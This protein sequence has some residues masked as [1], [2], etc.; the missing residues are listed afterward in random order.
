MNNYKLYLDVGANDGRWGLEACVRDRGTQVF[1]FEPVPEMINIIK[2]N[3]QSVCNQVGFISYHLEP[4]AVSDFSGTAKFH[5]SPQA[6]WGCSSLLEFKPLEEIKKTWPNRPD[7]N[8]KFD[9]DVNVIKLEDWCAEH[10]IQVNGG[11]DFIHIDAQG[12]DLQVLKGLGKYLRWVKA[13]EI[14]AAKSSDTAIYKNQTSTTDE[15]VKFLQDN[16][17]V[18]DRVWDN[19]PQANEQNIIFHRVG[20]LPKMLCPNGRDYWFAT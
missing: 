11:I 7:I 5:V 14:E 20:E 1:A 4:F 16:G 12:S 15:C 13:G 6:D 8:N 9:I 18:I 10:H 19:D 17:F 3:Q 2:A